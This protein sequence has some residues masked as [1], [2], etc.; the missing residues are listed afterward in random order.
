MK[1]R[2]LVAGPLLV[3][4]ALVAWLVRPRHE[5]IGQAYVST[6]T[7]TL[8]DSRAQVHQAVATLHFGDKLDVVSRRGE[9]ARVRTASGATG[10]IDTQV[11]MEP[12]LWQRSAQLLEKAQAMPVQARGRTKVPTNVRVEPGRSAP[13]LYQF[14]RGAPVEVISRAVA[15]WTQDSEEKEGGGEQEEVKKEDWFLVRGVASRGTGEIAVRDTERLSMEG[16]EQ[17]VP[18]AGWVVARFVEL[19]LPDAVREGALATGMRV[20]AWFELNRVQDPSGEMPQYL[21]AGTRG[22]EGQPCD[23]T[24]LRVYTWSK[25]RGRYETAYIES[26]LCGELPIRVGK[27]P[28]GDPEFRFAEMGASSGSERVYRLRQTIV[29][30]VREPGEKQLR[31]GHSFPAR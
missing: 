6:R 21:A 19:D 26:D 31:E 18:V 17:G 9:Q 1:R 11:L 22:P 3:L 30:R 12:L 23:F 14:N 10:W 20:L 29:R 25:K 7:A 27:S 8:W 2:V 24:M 16:E 15:D 28:G 4:V 5:V 13:R